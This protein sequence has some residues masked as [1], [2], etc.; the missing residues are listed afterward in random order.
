VK[1]GERLYITAKMAEHHVGRVL[2]KVGLRN[3]TEAAAYLLREHA[4]SPQA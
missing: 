3:R 1:I 2:S 4:R